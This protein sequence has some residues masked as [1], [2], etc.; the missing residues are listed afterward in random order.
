MI[1]LKVVP[2]LAVETGPVAVVIHLVIIDPVNL[3][4]QN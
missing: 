4:T 3:N 1:M 2:R